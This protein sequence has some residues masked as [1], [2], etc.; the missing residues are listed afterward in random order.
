MTA[1]K[2]SK[3][4]NL[5]DKYLLTSLNFKVL[6]LVAT[7][8]TAVPF[9]HNDY[10]GYVK[11]GLAYGILVC[12]WCFFNGTIKEL[13]KDKWNWVLMAFAGSYLISIYLNRDINFTKNINQWVYMLIF[14]LVLFMIPRWKSTKE[15]K[16][17]LSFI[18]GIVIGVTFFYSLICF[19][20]FLFDY[21]LEYVMSEEVGA[22][23]YFLGMFVNRL[24]GLYNPNTGGM[25]N[26]IS[27]ILS[28]Q[29][30]FE[31]KTLSKNG[32][33]TKLGMLCVVF[34]IVLQMCC[35]ILTSS[36]G[37]E[38][39][40]LIC[41]LIG[42]FVYILKTCTKWSLWMRSI[43]ALV[44]SVIVAA[45]CLVGG[46]IVQEG[47]AYLPAK[48]ADVT[49]NEFKDN[50]GKNPITSVATVPDD[51]ESKNAEENSTESDAQKATIERTDTGDGNVLT[52]R[53]FLWE[54][55]LTLWK[56]NP[57]FGLTRE[58]FA[59]DACTILFEITGTKRFNVNMKTGG[60]HN[61]YVT[62][63]VSS[64][65]VGFILLASFVA[66]VLYKSVYVLWR[67]KGLDMSFFMAFLLSLLFFA[68]EFIEARILYQVGVFNVLFWIYFGYTAYL[69]NTQ[70]E[71]LKEA[72][73]D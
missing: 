58:G 2:E 65:V 7:M 23:S 37:S 72:S 43:I 50:A 16:S 53:N 3:V 41:I 60:L 55:G 1:I 10:G 67:K 61:I 63:L 59:E 8:A 34:N 47:L 39:G 6:M 35:L 64:G 48:V 22:A 51:A 30:F 68:T 54:A 4:Y 36:R 49:G 32:T 38:Y 5:I 40:L 20:T 56:D 29:L 21:Q 11:Y 52:G 19:T 45:G 66:N 13:I 9:L 62:V 57:V 18:S 25:L 17:E 24:W 44:F 33:A 69:A 14:F 46:D 28:V 70:Y 27:I 26:A 15:V 12:L 31:N 73:S 42:I 71:S